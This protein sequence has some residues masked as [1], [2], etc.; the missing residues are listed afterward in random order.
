MAIEVVL[1]L[2]RLAALIAVVLPLLAV[3]QAVLGQRGGVAE[4]LRAGGARLR[5]GLATST[6]LPLRGWSLVARCGGVLLRTLLR[7]RSRRGGQ[8]YGYSVG[9]GDW[10]RLS[11]ERLG[12]LGDGRP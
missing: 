6:R 3:G 8:V 5:T 4:G 11:K 9:G 1:P 7:R 12:L 10:R 2:E